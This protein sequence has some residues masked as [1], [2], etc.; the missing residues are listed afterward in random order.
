MPKD[1]ARSQLVILSGVWN[2]WS[3]PNDSRKFGSAK[4][5]KVLHRDFCAPDSFGRRPSDGVPLYELWIRKD[6]GRCPT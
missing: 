4:S 3:E 2:D 6:S 1:L 5:T